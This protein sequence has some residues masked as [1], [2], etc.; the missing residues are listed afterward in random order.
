MRLPCE[1]AIGYE[2]PKIRADLAR[3]LIKEGLIQK[4]MPPEKCLED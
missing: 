2:I 3:E 1:H 4:T